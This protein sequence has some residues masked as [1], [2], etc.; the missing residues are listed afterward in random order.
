MANDSPAENPVHAALGGRRGELAGHGT[1]ELS[2]LMPCLNEA[3]TLGICID[4][5]QRL[6]LADRDQRRGP[7]RRQRLRPTAARRSRAAHGARVVAVAERGY[8]AALIAGIRAARGRFVI[9]G[10]SDNSYD[11]ANLDLFVEKLRDGYDVVMGNRFRGGIA[12]AAMPPLHR[13]LGNP[14]L[15]FV[16]RLFFRSRDRR[17]PLRPARLLARGGARPRPRLA[18][19]G[20][21]LRD[22]GEGDDRRA[23]DHRGADDAARRTAAR[24]RR[25]SGAG[26]TAG[27]T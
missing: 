12:E 13:Y 16:G 26:A 24:G 4:K 6:S 25:I 17:L 23:Q 5:A 11:F 14:V 2:I 19:H 18:G 7:D 27:G 20:V 9:M 1:V 10:D 22:G 3:E 21:R 15:S 8:G